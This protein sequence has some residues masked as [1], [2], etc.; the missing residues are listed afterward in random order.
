MIYARSSKGNTKA[1]RYLAIAAD[2]QPIGD[3]EAGEV[4]VRETMRGL[5]QQEVIAGR[6]TLL[7][8]S[9]KRHGS[10]PGP[11]DLLL[12][13]L[14]ACTLDDGAAILSGVDLVVAWLS[15]PCAY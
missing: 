6:H 2:V 12:A 7:P 8:M 11:Y 3:G 13:A 1:E 14:G 9:R 5:F 10:G 15:R 4:V